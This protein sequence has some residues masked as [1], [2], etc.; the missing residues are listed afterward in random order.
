MLEP[1]YVDVRYVNNEI[2]SK[3]GTGNTA[4]DSRYYTPRMVL[5]DDQLKV[6]VEIV[7]GVLQSQLISLTMQIN[8]SIAEAT[9][10][11]EQIHKLFLDK[12]MEHET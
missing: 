8:L 12:L 9:P 2:I 11:K 6:I 4:W 7:C 10:T 3:Y 1:P 5:T